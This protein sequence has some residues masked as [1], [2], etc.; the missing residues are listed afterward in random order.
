M[1]VI[2]III[3]VIIK[4]PARKI[5]FFYVFRPRSR[6]VGLGSGGVAS[7]CWL[8]PIHGATI[9]ALVLLNRPGL[10]RLKLYT[11]VNIFSIVYTKTRG[12]SPLESIPTIIILII[13]H[14]ETSH[15]STICNERKKKQYNRYTGTVI[16]NLIILLSPFRQSSSVPPASDVV[17]TPP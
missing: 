3:D 11:S 14:C 9:F 8:F 12:G 5:F 16:I 17:S 13:D 7:A 4:S 1:T 10:I 15:Q 2:I 6:Q